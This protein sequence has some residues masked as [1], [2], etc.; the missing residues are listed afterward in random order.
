MCML[1]CEYCVNRLE[2]V[3]ISKIRLYCLVLV[4]VVIAMCVCVG[5]VFFWVL[6]NLQG[7]LGCTL[8]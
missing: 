1:L 7:G 2:V 6:C 3:P 4:S 5:L 8:V